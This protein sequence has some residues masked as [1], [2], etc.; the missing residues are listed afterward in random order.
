MRKSMRAASIAVGAIDSAEL[1]C[2][3]MNDGSCV[4]VS[5]GST[6]GIMAHSLCRVSPHWPPCGRPDLTRSVAGGDVSPGGK[7]ATASEAT[8]Q[9]LTHPLAAVR[10]ALRPTYWPASPRSRT[11][12]HASSTPGCVRTGS[13]SAG[14]AETAAGSSGSAARNSA[15][16]ERGPDG[17]TTWTGDPPAGRRRCRMA[18][19]R[20]RLPGADPPPHSG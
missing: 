19:I 6:R 16:R 3:P 17:R 7:S 10:L 8:H 13:G 2:A 14:T 5:R 20:G 4:M 1:R 15:R 12:L 9:S 11:R 18:V